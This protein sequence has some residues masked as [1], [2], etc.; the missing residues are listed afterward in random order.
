M[1]AK[2]GIIYTC[3]ILDPEDAPTKALFDPV[4]LARPANDPKNELS[5]PVVLK[6]PA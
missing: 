4:V 5:E 6:L 1:G 3:C 2:E